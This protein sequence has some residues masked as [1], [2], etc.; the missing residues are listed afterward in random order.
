MS[1]SRLDKPHCTLALWLGVAGL[2]AMLAL[3]PYLFQLMPQQFA[4]SHNPLWLVIS[5]MSM[6]AGML[7]F[8]FA[9]LGLYL[10]AALSLDAPW[11]RAFVYSRPVRGAAPPRW[12]LAVL[13][14]LLAG[15]ATM[16]WPGPAVGSVAGAAS[17]A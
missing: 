10:G 11:L 12:R 16:L 8:A 3:F 1:V 9:W 17:Q 7:C 2:L 6:Q 15:A 4:T 14:G 13:L 5:L